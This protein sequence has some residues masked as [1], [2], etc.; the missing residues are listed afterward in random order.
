MFVLALFNMTMPESGWLALIL[1]IV[2]ILL[3]MIWAIWLRAKLLDELRK[4]KEDQ[5]QEKNLSDLYAE[6]VEYASD[7]VLRLDRS[8]NI[9][10]IN[11]AGAALL[12]Y[13]QANLIG[14]NIS[15]FTQNIVTESAVF[16]GSKEH[17]QADLI[18]LDRE[19]Q[20][21]HLEM[22]LRRER[23]EGKTRSLE[24][25][26]RNTTER[27]LLEA[28]FRHGERMQAMGLLAGGVAHD[29]NNYL[30][31]ILNFADLAMEVEPTEDVKQMLMEI[32]KAALVASEMSRHML[33][34]SRR[35][36]KPPQ[37]LDLNT[38]I[39]DSQRML[40]SALGKQI[41]LKLQLSSGL[42]S[43][44]ADIGLVEQV[45][46]NL[47]LNAR[48]AIPEVGK[49]TIRS[50]PVDGTKVMLEIEDTGSGIEAATL[51]KLFQPF[52]TTKEPGKGTGL[53]LASVHR[54]MNKLGGSIQV[55]SQL[56]KGTIFQLTFP[57]AY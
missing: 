7:V 13:T 32:R 1:F 57:A 9:L 16:D 10:A 29:F 27:R 20:P 47:V 28:Q 50:L 14:K 49:V 31:V 12:G 19:K 48:D 26:A 54:I 23:V 45:L 35:Q 11:R 44:F 3:L 40:H 6:M 46:M 21:V 18:L 41:T 15:E 2:I 5:T 30:T 53:G 55:N 17:A 51:P 25:I 24:I 37:K 56:G 39:Q 33:D 42:P 8:G 22:S 43:I 52:F 38:I 4:K 36:I 34:F